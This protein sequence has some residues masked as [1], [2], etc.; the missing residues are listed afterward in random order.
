V[1]VPRVAGDQRG[2][3]SGGGSGGAGAVCAEPAAG[4]AHLGGFVELLLF[5]LGAAGKGV[6]HPF[7]YGAG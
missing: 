6:Q 1:G 7:G 4:A 5:A 3:G 2:G